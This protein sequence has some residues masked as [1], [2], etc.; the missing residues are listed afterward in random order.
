MAAALLQNRRLLKELSEET[1]IPLDTWVYPEITCMVSWY[2]ILC[3]E[4]WREAGWL[5]PGMKK[6]YDL[7]CSDTFGNRVA[8]MDLEEDIISFPPSLLIAG[9]RD[10]L[11]LAES[12]VQAHNMLQRKKLV[13]KLSLYDDTHG[14]VSFPVQ[15]QQALTGESQNPRDATYET[16]EWLKKYHKKSY[17]KQRI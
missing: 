16:I 15:L 11:G 12:S 4:H 7:Y 10:P 3:S 2:S 5:S 17:V 6:V 8:L 13:S 9:T 1:G 14:F